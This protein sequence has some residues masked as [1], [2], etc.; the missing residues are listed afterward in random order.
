[1]KP[2]KPINR[3]TPLKPGKAQLAKKPLRRVSRKSAKAQRSVAAER[4]AYRKRFKVCPFCHES[5]PITLHEIR[6]GCHRQKTYLDIRFWRPGCWECHRECYQHMAL[7]FQLAIK[8]HLD[9]ENYSL[10]AVRELYA[11]E[12]RAPV[13]ITQEEVDE[14]LKVLLERGDLIP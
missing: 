8:L 10:E 2:R 6:G 12:D 1:M 4:K 5:K 13:V 14:A 11:T 3:Y 7:A 9:R